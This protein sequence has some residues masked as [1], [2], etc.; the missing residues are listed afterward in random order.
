MSVAAKSVPMA[1]RPASNGLGQGPASLDIEMLPMEL[2]SE[3]ETQGEGH[4]AEESRTWL[5]SESANVQQKVMGEDSIPEPARSYKSLYVSPAPEW[6][7]VSC[8]VPSKVWD[9]SR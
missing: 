1:S 4:N 7:V 6:Y 2:A 8:H 3:F 5:L 9:G